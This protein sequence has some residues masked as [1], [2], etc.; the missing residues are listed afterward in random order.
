MYNDFIIKDESNNSEISTKVCPYQHLLDEI[1][2]S[3]LERKYEVFGT[4]LKLSG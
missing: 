3:I 1:I 4:E 2:A